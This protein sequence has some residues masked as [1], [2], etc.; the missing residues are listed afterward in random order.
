MNN[1]VY[2]MYRNS[3]WEVLEVVTL[4]SGLSNRAFSRLWHDNVGRL[5]PRLHG[6]SMLCLQM[7]LMCHVVANN[8]ADDPSNELMVVS[9]LPCWHKLQKQT[10]VLWHCHVAHNGEIHYVGPDI[11][12]KARCCTLRVHIALTLELLM[13]FVKNCRGKLLLD[14]QHIVLGIQQLDG[15]LQV[16]GL[17]LMEWCAYG[18]VV[19][20]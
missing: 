17:D 13:T 4:S 2:C 14:G 15:S 10:T 1:L 12:C 9:L 7:L 16:H 8:V 19:Y 5:W 20:G 11:T 6:S 18:I 3:C